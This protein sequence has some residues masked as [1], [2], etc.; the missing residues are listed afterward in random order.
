MDMLTGKLNGLAETGNR[1]LKALP[2]NESRLLT[3]LLSQAVFKQHALLFEARETVERA[4]F[5]VDAVMSLVVPASPSRNVEAATVGRD[6]I[7]GGF[8]ILNRLISVS[9]ANV[10]LEGTVQH[11]AVNELQRLLNRCPVLHGLVGRYEHVLF[12]QAQQAAACNASHTLES[13]LARWLLRLRDLRG[14][15]ELYLTQD[16]MAEM[17]GVGRTTVSLT[18]HQLRSA[19][20]I[21]YR[22]GRI[23]I[24]QPEMLRKIS[25]GCYET[26][27]EN[28]ALLEN[29]TQPGGLGATSCDV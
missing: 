18:A 3:P 6:G 19:Q 21:T 28:C 25:C 27:K 11:C 2:E 29:E 20:L 26:L 24:D 9:R 7:L 10:L 4:Y 17:L 16:H 22:R 14:S 12:A 5:P 15:D 23:H 13:R 8:A 1:I